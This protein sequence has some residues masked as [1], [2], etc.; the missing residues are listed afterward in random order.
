MLGASAIDV[1][2]EVRMKFINN[3]AASHGGAIYAKYIA[4]QN[5]ITDTNCFIRPIEPET[6]PNDWR[7]TM[8]FVDNTENNGRCKNAIFTTSVLHCTPLGE[9]DDIAEHVKQTF[10][11]TGW[12]FKM[13][14]EKDCGNYI[15]S[16]IG[17]IVYN[18]S[19]HVNAYPGWEFRIPI[20]IAD[21]FG[22]DVTDLA[23]FH[24]DFDDC[25]I[26]L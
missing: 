14:F 13:N 17:N 18:G 22:Y 7:I 12:T 9:T 15:S 8:T 11:W 21:D 23:V 19:N 3:T 24:F 6:D 1:S 26:E 25:V 10:N 4:R 20:I 16:D 5:L 2:K